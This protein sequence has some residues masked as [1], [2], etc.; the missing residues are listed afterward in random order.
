MLF[1][2]QTLG[3]RYWA[4]RHVGSTWRTPKFMQVGFPRSRG[5]AVPLWAHDLHGL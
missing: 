1:G 4:Y 2:V 3:V 5:S